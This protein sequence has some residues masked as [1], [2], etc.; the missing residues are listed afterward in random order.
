[1]KE[2]VLDVLGNINLLD[3]PLIQMQLYQSGVLSHIVDI[4]N[5][6]LDET[7]ADAIER[8]ASEVTLLLFYFIIAVFAAGHYYFVLYEYIAYCWGRVVNLYDGSPLT[9]G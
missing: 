5:T 1:M 9:N 6:S 4:I 2:A 3:K 8:I 7:D